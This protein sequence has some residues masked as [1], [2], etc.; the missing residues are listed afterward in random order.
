[1]LDAHSELAIPGESNFLTEMIENRRR[2][3]GDGGL[4]AER[5]VAD[6]LE[7]ERF[8]LWGLP[9]GD[10]RRALATSGAL[11]LAGAV[12]AL[13]ALY[14]ER[15]GKQRYGDKTP[16]H[17]LHIPLFANLLPEARFVHLIRDGRDVALSLMDVPHWGPTDVRTA[18]LRW[19]QFVEAGREGARR[20][21]PERYLELRY[22]D[23][24]SSADQALRRICGFID[25]PFEPEMLDYHKHLDSLLPTVSSPHI[26]ES[27]RRPLTAGLRDWRTQMT[28]QDKL[29]F[30]EIAGPLL[31][32]LGYAQPGD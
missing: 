30:Q 10:L 9:P 16:N 20:I 15:R 22:E 27:L 5:F 31:K 1:M 7:S 12:R 24:V 18:A 23:L 17:V 8:L 32:E 29:A 21:E 25:L 11:D 6:L 28:P 14:A 2:Y 3:E 4:A 13:Y 19:Q 26:H